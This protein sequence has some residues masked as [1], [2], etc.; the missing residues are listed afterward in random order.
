MAVWRDYEAG[1]RDLRRSGPRGENPN[2]H[3]QITSRLFVPEGKNLNVIVPAGAASDLLPF[4]V[5]KP[6]QV[7]VG[8]L[9]QLS[10]D[11]LLNCCGLGHDLDLACWS[12]DLSG[13]RSRLN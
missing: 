4:F 10:N 2:Q 1:N 9:P 11:L 5:E 13:G 6:L 8:R 3:S 12:S 7:G